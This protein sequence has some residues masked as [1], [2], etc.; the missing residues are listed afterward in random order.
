MI[1]GVTGFLG[2][3]IG[4]LLIE[5]NY[6]V[7]ATRRNRSILKN[8]VEFQE[9][10]TWVNINED[11]WKDKIIAQKPQ[12]IIHAAWTGVTA[13]ERDNWELQS[14]N[15]FFL[16]DLLY[17]A[18]Q[19]KTQKVIGLGSHAEYGFIDKI[20]SETYPL[21]P[22]N[23]YGVCKIIN[24]QLL[25]YYCIMHNIQWY[26]FRIFSIFGEKESAEWL[27]PNVIQNIVAKNSN[28]MA[29]TPGEQQ[30]AYLYINDF[31]NA[32]K[33]VIINQDNTSGYYNISALKPLQ[34]KVIITLIRDLIDQ[35]FSL[36]FGAL[37]YRQNQ[38]MLIA[39]D[40]THF[41]EVFGS[42]QTTPLEESINNVINYYTR[43]IFNES[44]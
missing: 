21:N 15:L 35:N 9:Q 33:S 26:W 24:S 44:I 42:L 36:E 3:H 2:C 39:G 14:K 22:T 25:K 27:F 23:A 12:I 8:C 38:S 16:Q 30:Y 32:I 41:N 11:N 40:M 5:N 28:K 4:K 7:I 37:P 34:L 43:K 6:Q 1:T 20:V 13:I 10:I 29:F 31:A 18:Q 17:I 19:S